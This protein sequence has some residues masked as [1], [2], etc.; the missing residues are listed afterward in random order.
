[1]QIKVVGLFHGFVIPKE[2]TCVGKNFGFAGTVFI[3]RECIHVAAKD[4][5]EGEVGLFLAVRA[6]LQWRLGALTMGNLIVEENKV[7][8][9]IWP[10]FG[11]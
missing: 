9:G 2:D 6:D 5:E 11:R 4:S 7:L 10:E 1:V 3:R 8:K